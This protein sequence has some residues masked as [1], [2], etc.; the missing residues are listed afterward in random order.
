VE[1]LCPSFTCVDKALLIG[2]IGP[3]GKVAYLNPAPTVDQKFVDVASQ[4]RPPEQRFRFAAPCVTSSCAH[5][6]GARCAVVDHA[7]SVAEGSTESPAA[8]SSEPLPR[9]AVRSQCRWFAQRGRDACKACPSVFNYQP[10]EVGVE[11]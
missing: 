3:D 8:T 4:G 10:S 7:L 2:I 5:W 1:P 11:K 6:S 9:C